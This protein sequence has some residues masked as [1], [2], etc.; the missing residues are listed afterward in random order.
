MVRRIGWC[1]GGKVKQT[2]CEHRHKKCSLT[3][4]RGLYT[5]NI[6]I[7]FDVAVFNKKKV[8]KAGRNVTTTINLSKEL[9]EK[10]QQ[11]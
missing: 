7:A 1:N 4:T 6:Y 3:N 9:H 5:R 8:S 2:G 10:V 11:D